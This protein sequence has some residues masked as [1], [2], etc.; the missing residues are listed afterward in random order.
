MKK[1]YIKP[2]MGMETIE[3]ESMIAASGDKTLKIFDEEDVAAT[4]GRGM[5]SKDRDNSDWGG[6]W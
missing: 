4:T 1:T 6:L 5:D 2:E 3:L